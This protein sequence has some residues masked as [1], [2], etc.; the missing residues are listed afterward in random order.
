MNQNNVKEGMV[1]Y[2]HNS[3][4][5]KTGVISKTGKK[6]SKVRF[7]D[8]YE[9]IDNRCLRIIKDK[10]WEEMIRTRVM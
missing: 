8:N 7:R 3:G 10:M 9:W 2:Y 4:S 6:K 5:P 1:V